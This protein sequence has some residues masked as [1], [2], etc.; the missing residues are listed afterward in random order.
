M[1]FPVDFIADVSLHHLILYLFGPKITDLSVYFQPAW[2]LHSVQ[3]LGLCVDSTWSRQGAGPRV[4]HVSSDV[5]QS[6]DTSALSGLL[7]T[8]VFFHNYCLIR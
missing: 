1:T 5:I 8:S 2:I 3:T 6:G 7:L 4:V